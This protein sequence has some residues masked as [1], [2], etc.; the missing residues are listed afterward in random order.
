MA[1]E[2]PYAGLG[3]WYPWPRCKA[4]DP[5][6]SLNLGQHVR[7]NVNGVFA[8]SILGNENDFVGATPLSIN[9][10]CVDVVPG[11][12]TKSFV[13]VIPGNDPAFGKS[14]IGWILHHRDPRHYH[15]SFL[16]CPDSVASAYFFSPIRNLS[17]TCVTAQSLGLFPYVGHAPWRLILFG[18]FDM[19]LLQGQIVPPPVCAPGPHIFSVFAST[20]WIPNR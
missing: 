8:V 1:T 11:S 9:G 14:Q 18:V 3:L 4:F 17:P 16:D 13:G 19:T 5:Q 6:E 7:T 10:F 12:W 2:Q 20:K 15:L